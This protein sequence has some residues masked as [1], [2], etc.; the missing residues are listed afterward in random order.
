MANSTA[1]LNIRTTAGHSFNYVSSANYNEVYELRQEV[2]NSNTFIDMINVGTSIAAQT[3]RDS[4]MVVVHNAGQTGLEIQTTIQAWKNNSNVDVVNSID[5][6]DGAT[7]LRYINYLLPA[8]DFMYLPNNRCVSY[9]AEVGV[10]AC[11]ATSL[12]DAAPSAP[13]ATLGSDS[14]ATLGAHLDEPDT[15]VTVN[16]TDYFKI[17]DLIQVG[18]NAT[19]ATR[20]EVMMVTEITST[21]VMQVE[22]GLY[23]T[24]K[25]DKDAQTDAT[26]GAVSGAK[27]FFPTFNA[28]HDHDKFSLSQ[29]D[30]QGRFKCF[31][32]FGYGRTSDTL[33]EG[34]VPGSVAI[35]FYSQ[36]TI[37]VGLSSISGATESGLTGGTTYEFAVNPG[38]TEDVTFTVDSSNTKFGGNNGVI[39][40]IQT[41]L[42]AKFYDSSSEL[43]EK[44]ITVSIVNGDLQFRLHESLSTSSLSIAQAAD[45][46]GTT[47]LFHDTASTGRFPAKTDI[48]GAVTPK[49]PI[50]QSIS[51]G[52]TP[53]TRKVMNYM[54]DDG[55]GNLIGTNGSG[56]INYETGALDFTSNPL[57]NF[58]ITATY[59]SAMG[60][61]GDGTTANGVNIIK[62]ISARSTSQKR[63]GVCS[64][65]AF[66]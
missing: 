42:D 49:L 15:Q 21:T 12:T 9:E 32:F 64:I 44:Q 2:D 16:D 46:S 22:R 57:S 53:Q 26:E 43:F 31:N 17:G 18:T 54:T 65:I 19:T 13:G 55:K 41:A 36:P 58:T 7:V 63:D 56:R 48:R 4:K 25:A 23:G 29:T 59:K 62:Q 11:N 47:N 45:L 39:R 51:G 38:S 3:L 1:S 60:G 33:A 20:K 10:S 30:R 50:K 5:T 37:S 35:Q 24:L 28:Y 8:G 40:K 34:L 6:G 14:G 61:T 52:F 66:N 27:V